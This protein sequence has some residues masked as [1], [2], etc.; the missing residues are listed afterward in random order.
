M[1]RYIHPEKDTIDQQ[2]IWIQ[3]RNGGE[4]WENQSNSVQL[5]TTCFVKETIWIS[6]SEGTLNRIDV[7]F[8]GV[9]PLLSRP[10][11]LKR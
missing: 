7:M 2:N 11:N 1:E 9:L 3:M 6:Y 5:I 8:M 4:D 10:M